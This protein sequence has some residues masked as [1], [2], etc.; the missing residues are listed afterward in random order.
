MNP[1]DSAV[2]VGVGGSE[3]IAVAYL[4]ILCQQPSLQ[5]EKKTENAE[6]V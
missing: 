3:E 6:S 4:K 1:K 2:G 5:T